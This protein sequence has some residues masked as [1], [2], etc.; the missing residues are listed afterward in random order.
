[1][2]VSKTCV[3]EH[4]INTDEVKLTQKPEKFFLEAAFISC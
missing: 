1:M 4:I 3:I 2:S